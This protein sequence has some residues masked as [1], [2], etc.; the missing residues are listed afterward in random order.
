MSVGA[1]VV[2]KGVGDTLGRSVG[3]CD[4]YEDGEEVKTTVGAKVSVGVGDRVVED[5]SESTIVGCEVG[6]LL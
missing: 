6:L 3:N 5:K 4:G 2:G 1:L